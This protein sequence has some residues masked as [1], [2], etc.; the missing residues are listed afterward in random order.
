MRLP[1]TGN[2]LVTALIVN[3]N[4]GRFLA[5]AV[6]SALAQTYAPLE[7]LVV[8]DGSTDDSR[9]R[10]AIYEGRIR[11]IFKSNGGQASGMNAGIAAARGEIIC[12]L[13]SD[14][15]WWPE[16][17]AAV[18]ES[19]RAADLGLVCHNLVE[20]GEQIPAERS[21]PGN[22]PPLPR[23]E[24]FADLARR[25][26]PWV[27]SPTSA[28]SL[29]AELARRITPFPEAEWRICA[30]N[31]L[32]FGAAYLAPVGAIERPLGYL[33]IHGK[34][35]FSKPN[36][37][38]DRQRYWAAEQPRAR[39]RYLKTLAAR[40]GRRLEINLHANY[41][42]LRNYC[43]VA[44]RF[45]LAHLPN[46]WRRNLERCRAGFDWRTVARALVDDTQM[47]LRAQ[48]AR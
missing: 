7:V 3:Y 17:V 14:D 20:C 26:L 21:D 29:P 19:Y 11:T 13:D 44:A 32:A 30:D 41:D 45:P 35:V 2:P 37:Q 10:L 48:R 9:A 34:N 33:R 5:E 12:F 6:D 1:R 8:D 25:A 16:K 4:Y 38:D 36:G 46:L 31:P 18:V 47:A 40:E 43:M 23:G 15:I 28:L 42:Y 24:I 39:L 22:P 27:F